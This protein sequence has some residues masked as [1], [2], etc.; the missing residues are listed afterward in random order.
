MRHY[1]PLQNTTVERR[2]I[3]SYKF[4]INGRNAVLTEDIIRHTSEEC[5]CFSTSDLWMDIIVHMKFMQPDAYIVLYPKEDDGVQLINQI[6]KLTDEPVCKEMAYVL[7]GDPEELEELEKKAPYLEILTIER[8]TSAQEIEE[9]TKSYIKA[10]EKKRIEEEEKLLEMEAAS[11]AHRAEQRALEEEKKKRKEEEKAQVKKAKEESIAVL[12]SDSKDSAPAEDPN[13][14]KHILIVDD[15]RNVLKLLKA[16]LSEKY[17]VT[18]M[19]NGKMAEKYLE[20]KTADLIL[21]DHEM[22]VESGLEVFQKIKANKN[23]GN[24]PVVF[25]TGTSD[26]A[27]IKEILSLHPKGYLLKPVDVD[28]LMTTIADALK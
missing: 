8:P 24:I 21:L 22:P 12:L 28:K 1:V 20:T 23:Q 7:I 13:V 19:L 18:A 26:A 2:N 17:E 11:K 27:K 6:R 3:M 4:L 14:K 25:L 16:T 15:D 10:L 9:R 5:T